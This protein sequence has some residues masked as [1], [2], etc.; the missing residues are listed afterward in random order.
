MAPLLE[1]IWGFPVI[2]A[3]EGGMDVGGTCLGGGSRSNHA[4]LRYSNAQ[5][6]NLIMCYNIPTDLLVLSL[7][8]K[9]GT[10]FDTKD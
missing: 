2:E 9:M 7:D 1:G 5:N 10:E 3:D 6:Y 4:C 8:G